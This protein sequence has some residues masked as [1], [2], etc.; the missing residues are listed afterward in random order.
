M[1]LLDWLKGPPKIQK[2]PHKVPSENTHS[3][4]ALKARKVQ[5]QGLETLRRELDGEKARNRNQARLIKEMDEKFE[6]VQGKFVQLMEK[7]T[8]TIELLLRKTGRTENFPKDPHSPPGN[9]GIAVAVTT[10]A[11]ELPDEVQ[12]ISSKG[13]KPDIDRAYNYGAVL[14]DKTFQTFV[15]D[16]SNRF[17][18]LA[19]EAVATG[20]G[21]KYNP[22]FVYGPPGVGKTHLLHALANKMMENDQHLKL[23]YS[24]TEIYTDELIAALETGDLNDFRRKYHDADVL[25]I[26]DIQT[27]S[28]K[29]N[30][31]MEFFH[32]FNHLYNLQKQI[33]LCSD[34]PPNEIKELE[35][36]L[37]SRFEGGLIIDI[38]LPTF[39]GRRQILFN[40]ATRAGISLSNEV[41][42]YMAY[43]LDSNVRELEGGFNRVTA[44]AGL[45]K[46]TITIT[47]V[48]KV[49]EGV[50]L[51][52]V[53]DGTSSMVAMAETVLE[54]ENP[55]P[56][57]QRSRPSM[58]LDAD[59]DRETDQL[60]KELLQEL[61]KETHSS[62]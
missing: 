53:P 6:F 24:S 1:G 31:Q 33:I 17:A 55:P 35:S 34:R 40:L 15:V 56:I 60:E 57:R 11:E 41:M 8:E 58:A 61:M 14:K 37:Q 7:Q 21:R 18:Y 49:L 39:E 9:D 54:V 13:V 45:M 38:N 30:T 4:E 32:L 5:E 50:L 25:L 10:S 42:D 51:K 26:D 47:L 20:V 2:D 62:S 59:L 3:D 28:G 36:R 23:L 48:R 22:L 44:Y 52:K 27:L 43:Y 16:E 29:E 19:T 12:T 46:E